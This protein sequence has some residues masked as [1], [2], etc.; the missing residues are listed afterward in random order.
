MQRTTTVRIERILQ[1]Q[2]RS[3]DNMSA[4]RPGTIAPIA[5]TTAKTLPIR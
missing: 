5:E 2:R 3:D 4:T 1:Q